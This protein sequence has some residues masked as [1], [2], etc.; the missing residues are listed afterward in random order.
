MDGEGQLRMAEGMRG[1]RP[2]H[3]H[4]Y[5]YR[6]YN[7]MHVFHASLTPSARICWKALGLV[8]AGLLT[9]VPHQANG[10]TI[11]ARSP[12]FIDVATAISLAK[13]GDTVV[14][15]AGSASW[16]SLLIVTKGI[17]LQGATTINGAGT[18]SPTVNDATTI[19]DNNATSGATGT[20]QVKINP[21]Q[22]AR[23]TGFTFK[24]GTGSPVSGMIHLVS[25]SSSAPI[26]S[27][28]VDHCHLAG[29]KA[30]GIQTDGWVYGV[31]DH[32][33]VES[34]ANGQCFYIN[35][36]TYGGQAQGHGAWADYPWFGTNKF[37]FMEDNTMTGQG[38]NT[39]NGAIDAELAGRFVMRH[40]YFINCRPGWHGTEGNT[41]GT[42]AVE[43]YHNIFDWTLAFSASNRS[44]TTLYHDN[45][46]VN[47]GS[48]NN[49]HATIAVY[50]EMG[51]VTAKS[52]YGFADGANPW[53]LN[54]TDGSGNP[55]LYDSGN[56]SAG[57]SA[58]LTDSSK[59]WT[60]NQW[61]GYSITQTNPSAPSY[62][63]CGYITSNT[64]NQITYL[65]YT[66]TDRGPILDFVANDKYQ[67]HR[68]QVAMD[69]VG[70]GKG[71]LMTGTGSTAQIAAVSKPG[72]PHEAL[73]PAMSWNNVHI[74][75]G[76]AYGFAT[77]FPTE[78]QG[79]D[80]YN[81]GKGFPADSTPSQVSS[82]YTAALNGTTYSRTYT[83]PHPLVSGSSPSPAAPEP[84]TNLQVV[85]GP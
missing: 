69:Q 75:T 47:R 17:T 83:Y 42:R 70:R 35:D 49:S 25:G 68:L 18:K 16:N 73:E 22:T 30:R 14:V 27:I 56:V 46:W 6:N 31:A 19:I 40:N 7:D 12:A 33:F 79:R 76:I 24:A 60:P 3:G 15:P 51:G 1:V 8:A 58:T 65:T 28:R 50:R 61:V 72:W 38:L 53:D 5:N 71:D 23:V 34:V 62:K 59:K 43:V 21:N 81:L 37:F 78:V 77:K 13:D 64:S 41:R 85:P 80:Y 2:W 48:N 39:T 32:N 82:I 66:T 4:C 10:A 55:K 9:I 57:G 74:P 67:I 44:G 45:Q 20:I 29:F 63:K 11:N 54:D 26:T 52:T 36:A 84:P